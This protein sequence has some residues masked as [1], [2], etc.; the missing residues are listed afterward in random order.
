MNP[1]RGT[2][3]CVARDPAS[4][5]LGV[6]VQSHW[7]SV[8]S[9]AGWARAGVGAVAT[10]SV[11]E[12]AYGPRLLDRLAAGEAAG[13]ALA[14]ELG[15]DDLAHYRQVAVVT[16]DGEATA[17]TGSGCIPDAGHRTGEG[18]SA[19]AN[20]M[21][22][23][24]VWPAMADAFESAGGPLARR[25]LATLEAGELAGGDLRGRQ[26]ASLLVVPGSGE[27]WET[28]VDL[29]VDDHPE[30][31]DELHRLLDLSDAYADAARADELA[32]AGRHEE[33]TRLYRSAAAASPANPE[34]R[35]WAALGAAAAGDL[36]AGAAEVG[37]VIAAVPAWGELLVRLD[38]EIA[39]GAD[40]VR[41]ALGLS[42]RL[43]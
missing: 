8:G 35:F 25:L 20:M 15:G 11:A 10:Q 18:Y 30:P 22:S 39:P 40:A 23:A 24:A 16:G 26:S 34:L 27:G 29:R 21:A 14:A 43:S 17:H 7:F 12:P 6:A 28:I 32:A 36:E 13:D 42:P 33:A 5:V 38:E 1:R 9:I 2:Y 4:G 37:E 31:L 3:S 41:R 19:Q